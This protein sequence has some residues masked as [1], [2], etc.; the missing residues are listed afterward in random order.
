M[1][2]PL[3]LQ[4]LK[5]FFSI[6]SRLIN[7]VTGGTADMT[8]SAR[9]HINELWTQHAIDWIAEHIFNEPDHCAKAW[10]DEV[11]RSLA[12]LAKTVSE[13]AKITGNIP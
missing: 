9:S 10:S 7:V 5:E 11:A 1:T 13:D 2:I 6:C 12:V 4:F 3:I 8:F